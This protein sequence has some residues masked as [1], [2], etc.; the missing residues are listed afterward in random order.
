LEKKS[1]VVFFWREGEHSE[2][3]MFIRETCTPWLTFPL[4]SFTL[5]Q[6]LVLCLLPQGKIMALWN[7]EYPASC[8][9]VV[10]QAQNIF[11]MDIY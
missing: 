8:S 1:F 9:G 10:S 4:F 11:T 6:Q 7:L 2:L 5:S 3:N